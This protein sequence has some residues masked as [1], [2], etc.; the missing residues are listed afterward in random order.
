MEKNS[1]QERQL[2]RSCGGFDEKMDALED[3][4]LWI[5]MYEKG[6]KGYVLDEPLYKMRDDRNAFSRR[7]FKYRINEMKVGASAVKKLKLPAYNYIKTIRPILVG[8]LPA[9]IYKRL[10]KAKRQ[11]IQ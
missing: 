5:R 7:K 9:C 8:L 10:H 4:D 6:Y 1:R 3:W 11:K 2:L